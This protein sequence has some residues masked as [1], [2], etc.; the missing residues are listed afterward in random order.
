MSM[1]FKLSCLMLL[2]IQPVPPHKRCVLWKRKTNTSHFVWA[3]FIYSVAPS[4]CF[5]HHFST[6]RCDVSAGL[7]CFPGVGTQ[8]GRA[9]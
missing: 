9:A 5:A 8:R 7:I 6:V 3:E 4:D 1:V 2:V